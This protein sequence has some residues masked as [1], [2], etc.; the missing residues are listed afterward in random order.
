MP[1]KTVVFG[2]DS[3]KLTPLQFRQ[4]SGRAGRRGFDPAGTVIFMTLPTSKIR[5]LLTASL[6]TLRGNAP[7]TTSF[8]LRLFNYV[9]GWQNAPA[10]AMKDLS[11]KEKTSKKKAVLDTNDV[12]SPEI[13]LKVCFKPI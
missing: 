13:R 2:I 1:C 9:L 7:Y 11:I 4:M 12:L 6:Q 10:A 3:P 8:F 5:R